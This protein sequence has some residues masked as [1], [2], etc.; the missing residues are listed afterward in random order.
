MAV[1]APHRRGEPDELAAAAG[2]VPAPGAVAPFKDLSAPRP[3]DGHAARR[4]G[5]P[6]PGDVDLLH[7]LHRVGGVAGEDVGQARGQS[8]AGGEGQAGLPGGVVEVEE[9]AHG[10]GVVGA[11]GS[12]NPGLHR[13]LEDGPFRRAADGAGDDIDPGG[14]RPVRRPVDGLGPFSHGLGGV[15]GG[16]AVAIGDQ[17]AFD[18]VG[19]GQL[20]SGSAS[21]RAG[22]HQE[23]GGHRKSGSWSWRQPPLVGGAP[24][25]PRRRSIQPTAPANPRATKV[26]RRAFMSGASWNRTSDLILIRDAL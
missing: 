5:R 11:P 13:S 24:P 9:A 20:S 21:D 14:Q 6:G 1:E 7:D 2:P 12:G 15:F 16:P 18:P 23:D 25:R 3:E 26:R 17:D 22:A 10:V 4:P 19:L 8:A